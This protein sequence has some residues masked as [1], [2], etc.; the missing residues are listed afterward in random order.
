MIRLKEQLE[1]RVSGLEAAAGVA[2]IP[3]PP[4]A[5]AIIDRLR[6]DVIADG[7][8]PDAVPPELEG[9]EGQALI[10]KVLK[11][12]RADSAPRE[13]TGG[14]QAPADEP[15][16]VEKKSPLVYRLRCLKPC[17]RGLGMFRVICRAGDIYSESQEI[18][19]LMAM[20]QEP[21]QYGARSLIKKFKLE[22]QKGKEWQVVTD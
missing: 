4:E 19:R 6:A 12:L 2:N 3:P 20:M 7:G 8:D 10:G 14:V 18:E 17:E 21:S 11:L 15:A 1:E 5:L 9:L 13:T 22:P 16:V